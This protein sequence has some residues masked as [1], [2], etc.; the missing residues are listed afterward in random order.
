MTRMIPL[1]LLLATMAACE[2]PPAN[3]PAPAPSPAPSP[4]PPKEPWQPP[5]SLAN[6]ALEDSIWVCDQHERQAVPLDALLDAAAKK[7]VV[8]LGETHLDET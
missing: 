1:L 3:D 2:S 6:A 4:E 7:E 8:F 5:E